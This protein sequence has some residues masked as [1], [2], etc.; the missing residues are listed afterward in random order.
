MSEVRGHRERAGERLGRAPRWAV[1]SLAALLAVAPPAV[2]QNALPLRHGQL[3]VAIGVEAGNAQEEFGEITAGAFVPDGRFLVLDR[4][5]GVLRVF[6]PDGGM[7]AAAGRPGSG[8]GEFR[9]PVQVHLLSNRVVLVLD[10]GLSR[11]SIFDLTRDSLTFRRS[12]Q[13]QS[14]AKEFCVLGDTLYVAGVRSA[15][16]ATVTR[17]TLDG[18][19][20]GTLGELFLTERDPVLAAAV[21]AR[22]RIGC[23]PA[24]GLVLVASD[25]LPAIRAYDGRTGERRWEVRLAAF[26]E[27]LLERKGTSVFFKVPPSQSIHQVDGLLGLNDGTVLVPLKRT[28][29]R[30]EGAPT[31]S[32][33]ELRLLSP[34][35]RELSMQRPTPRLVALSQHLLAAEDTTVDYPRVLIYRRP[36]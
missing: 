32:E 9:L 20:A 16:T 4:R 36:R 2:G 10:F 13:V 8:P 27:T 31:Q 5:F 12:F 21:S 18:R 17:Y 19:E 25:Y 33:H 3:V 7:M 24:K 6:S 28:W 22:L 30:A 29:R 1:T 23:L 26:Q 15:D 11:F 14:P 35:G 34:E